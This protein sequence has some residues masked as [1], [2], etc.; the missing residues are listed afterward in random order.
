MISRRILN[1]LK[2][3]LTKRTIL[4]VPG[5]FVLALFAWAAYLRFTKGYNWADGTGFEGKTLWDLL[6]LLI[7]PLV[8]AIGGLWFNAQQK[9]SE[10]DVATDRQRET[11]LQTYLDKMAELLLDKELVKNKDSE[12]D[13][14][15]DVAKTRTVTTLR[16]LDI[17]RRNILIQ[18]LRDA[19]L[20]SFILKEA[21]LSGVNLGEAN[22]SGAYM[23]G[24]RLG[25]ADLLRANLREA[26]LSGACLRHTDLSGAYMRN[27]DLSGADLLGANLSKA[28]LSGA[29]LSGA[30]V[31]D[32]QLTSVRTLEGAIMPD[33]KKYDPAIHNLPKK[34]SSK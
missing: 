29:N 26:D 6:E 25:I 2:E 16:I 23:R 28:D 30:T 32:E 15:V 22:L 10:Q 34:E 18:F 7:V 24:A 5:V 1:W 3:R 19:D 4:I 14:T 33:G 17:K 12:D 31:T 13:P 8:L 27:A 21:S 11:T 9:R 20:Y